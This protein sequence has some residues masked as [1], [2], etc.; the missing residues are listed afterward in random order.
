MTNMR[1]GE[2]VSSAEH[3]M[4]ENFQFFLAKFLFSKLEKF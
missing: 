1:I 3:R 2:I 4:G